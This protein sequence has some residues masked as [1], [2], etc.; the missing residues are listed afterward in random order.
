[1]PYRAFLL[2]AFLFAPV[3]SSAAGPCPTWFERLST[4]VLRAR[5]PRPPP[6]PVRAT[7]ESLVRDYLAGS[8]SAH[9]FLYPPAGREVTLYRANAVNVNDLEHLDAYLSPGANPQNGGLLDEGRRLDVLRGYL[10]RGE[11]GARELYRDHVRE[12]VYA[13]GRNNVNVVSSWLEGAHSP[14]FGHATPEAVRIIAR[15]RIGSET[16]V[17]NPHLG[18]VYSEAQLFTAPPSERVDWFVELGKT[19]F[20][21]TNRAKFAAFLRAEHAK[22]FGGYADL[23][24]ERQERMWGNY[25]KAAYEKIRD[26]AQKSLKRGRDIGLEPVEGGF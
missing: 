18:T 10:D 19:P 2:A 17:L 15:A 20:R 3:P 4:F 8:R 25:L 23:P 7:D 6:V 11:A 21:I 13:F 14:M 5:T 24:E 26:Q 16:P 9:P 1:V 12:R 22:Y